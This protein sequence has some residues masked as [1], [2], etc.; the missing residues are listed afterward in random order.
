METPQKVQVKKGKGDKFLNVVSGISAVFIALFI[1][2]MVGRYIFL[3]NYRYYPVSGTSMQPTINAGLSEQSVKDGVYIKYNEQINVNDIIIIKLEDRVNTIIKRVIAKGGDKISIRKYDE[4][5]NQYRVSVIR[6]G[7]E[8]IEILQEDYILSYPGWSYDEGITFGSEVYESRFYET[9]L[10]A[11]LE[12]ESHFVNRY[13]VS[14]EGD[15]YFVEVP[16]GEIFY[17]GDNRGA[18]LD[19][20]INGTC[21]EEQVV[22]VVKVIIRDVSTAKSNNTLWWE[23]IKA[24]FGYFWNEIGNFFAWS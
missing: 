8:N 15:T 22:G 23:K 7:S 9:F 19:A 13:D 21:T 12:P 24:V 17:M 5:D 16:E 6:D 11:T 10:K 20:R 1:A 18:S 3:A 4:Y 14:Y 2:F